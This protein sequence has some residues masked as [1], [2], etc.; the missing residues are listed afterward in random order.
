MRNRH[1]GRTGL[2]TLAMLL[3]VPPARGPT[4]GRPRW[5]WTPSDAP[6]DPDRS[7]RQSAPVS[8]R[9]A[10]KDDPTDEL[11]RVADRHRGRRADR[12]VAAS[13]GLPG[14]AGRPGRRRLQPAPRN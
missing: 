5:G 11:G 2:L 13:A 1:A 8:G 4:A 6:I 14:L 3:V 7:F 10:R 9:G 12:S